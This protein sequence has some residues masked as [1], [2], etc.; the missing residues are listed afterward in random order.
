MKN[1][2]L[3]KPLIIVGSV[4]V[5]LAAVLFLSMEVVPQVLVTLTK[6]SSP[7]NVSIANSYLIGQRILA[8]ADG[9]DVAVVNVFLLDKSGKGV[10][11][12]VAELTGAT[13]IKPL[14]SMTDSDGKMSFEIVSAT[15]GQFKINAISGGQQLPQTVTV[16]FRN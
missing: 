16:T 14:S 12:K 6:A 3:V 8:K 13:N 5:G 4:I 11:S 10:Q 15:E 7:E 2:K 9:K 1:N